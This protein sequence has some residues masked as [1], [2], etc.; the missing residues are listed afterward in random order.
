[1][2]SAVPWP[3]AVSKTISA[4]QLASSSARCPSEPEHA[5]NTVKQLSGC[6]WPSR[7]VAQEQN[8]F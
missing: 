2:I 8:K 4:R 6:P 5:A 7:I 1:M 3:S